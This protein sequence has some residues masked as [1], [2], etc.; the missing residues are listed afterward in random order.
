MATGKEDDARDERSVSFGRQ[1]VRRIDEE[2]LPQIKIHTLYLEHSVKQC[3]FHSSDRKTKILG[4]AQREHTEN[5]QRTHR[6]A[7]DFIVGFL[8]G[9]S[10]PLPCFRDCV[11]SPS[12]LTVPDDKTTFQVDSKC[13]VY[14]TRM[15]IFLN[16]SPSSLT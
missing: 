10:L 2:S 12:G 6:K 13:S 3:V 16:A 11:S 7:N 8:T 1:R 14:L 5:T 9:C 15:F 4:R